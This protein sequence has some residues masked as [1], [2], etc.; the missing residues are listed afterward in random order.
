MKS[1]HLYWVIKEVVVKDELKSLKE[2]LLV[3]KHH[4]EKDKL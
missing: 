3:E 1:P 4:E 2:K